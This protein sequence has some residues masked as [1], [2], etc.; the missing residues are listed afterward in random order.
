MISVCHRVRTDV[1]SRLD[2]SLPA[3]MI[4]KLVYGYN[5]TGHND[6]FI[7]LAAQLSS[8]TSESIEPGRWLVE[9]FPICMS[10]YSIERSEL[11]VK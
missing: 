5:I 4:L 6:R 3:A 9:S 10:P 8:I 2:G 7:E 11:S 1:S